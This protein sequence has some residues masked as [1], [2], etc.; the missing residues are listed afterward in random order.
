M[1][2]ALGFHKAME[3][4]N[5]QRPPAAPISGLEMNE[6]MPALRYPDTEASAI[7]FDKRSGVCGA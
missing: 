5:A 3:D 1:H 2:V 7:Q 6:W 4:F